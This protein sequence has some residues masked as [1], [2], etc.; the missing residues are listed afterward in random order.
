MQ[1]ICEVLRSEDSCNSRPAV[2]F[3]SER[4]ERNCAKMMKGG[5]GAMV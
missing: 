5:V 4:D 2:R 3:E 1:D